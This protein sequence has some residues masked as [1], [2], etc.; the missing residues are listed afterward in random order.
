MIGVP[1]AAQC[2]LSWCFRPVRGRRDT[3]VKCPYTLQGVTCKLQ[4][5]WRR[6]NDSISKWVTLIMMDAR[7]LTLSSV[8]TVFAVLQL[9]GK[10]TWNDCPSRGIHDDTRQL[11]DQYVHM[12]RHVPTHDGD[13]FLQNRLCLELSVYM[14][15]CS[16][17][18]RN[19]QTTRYSCV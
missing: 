16:I 3:L 19:Q 4:N 8:T 6:A 18:F 14:D 9:T 15:Q 2:C 17:R 5:V 7:L 1:S 10:Q 11:S 13:V 12:P